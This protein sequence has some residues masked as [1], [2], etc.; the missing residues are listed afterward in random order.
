VVNKIKAVATGRKGIHDDV[1][2]EP[3][4]INKAAVVD[5]SGVESV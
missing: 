5:A 1:P 3:V 4:V 2:Q